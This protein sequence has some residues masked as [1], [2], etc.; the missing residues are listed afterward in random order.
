ME[1]LTA[2]Q[3]VVWFLLAVLTARH[4]QAKD[5]SF[6][7]DEVVGGVVEARAGSQCRDELLARL[8]F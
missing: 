8:F 7:E 4:P 6:V 1:L 5:S 3:E 2:A